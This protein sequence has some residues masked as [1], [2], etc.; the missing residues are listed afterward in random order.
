MSLKN[1]AFPS[2]VAFEEIN[3]ALKASDAERKDA[4]KKANAIFA[5]KLKNKS[6]EEQSWHI[7]LK[8]DGVVRKGLVKDPTVTL[9]LSDEDFGKLIA[10]K[11]NAQK[12]FMTGSIRVSGDIM[13]AN[14]MQTILKKAQ[15]PKPKL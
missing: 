9:S 1:D 6:G 2:S 12:M 8:K 4:I 15:V 11:A 14:V 7:D 13:K 3:N 10:G 5:F